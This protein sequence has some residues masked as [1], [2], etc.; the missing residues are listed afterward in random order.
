MASGASVSQHEPPFNKARHT[1]KRYPIEP[2]AFLRY[3][4]SGWTSGANEKVQR[5]AQRV[6]CNRRLGRKCEPT[7][8]FPPPILP[9]ELTWRSR[10]ASAIRDDL[11]AEEIPS[12]KVEFRRVDV[13]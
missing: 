10:G 9:T 11:S 13:K 4:C 5:P 12:M 7:P 3:A 2:S 1:L 6:R 8:D